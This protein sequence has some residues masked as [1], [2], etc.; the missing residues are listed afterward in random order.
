M[1]RKVLE[2]KPRPP[3][4]QPLLLQLQQPTL[5]TPEVSPASPPTLGGLPCLSPGPRRSLLPL[6]PP[7][8]ERMPRTS[9]GFQ[10]PDEAPPFSNVS[11]HLNLGSG[12]VQGFAAPCS[13]GSHTSP[14]VASP[15][16]STVL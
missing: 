11:S 14:H 3:T 10:S 13:D 5:F 2:K 9:T 12:T 15:W 16:I 1:V 8:G 7:S 6:L 4:G